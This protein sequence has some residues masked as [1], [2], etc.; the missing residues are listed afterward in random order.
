MPTDIPDPQQLFDERHF[1]E[2]TGLLFEVFGGSRM[3]GRLWGLLVIA[4]EP[5]LSAAE[6]GDRL[7]ASA[8]SVSTATRVLTS[9]GLIERVRLPGDRRGYFRVREGGID[10]LMIQRQMVISQGR[11]LAERGLDEF[12]H[13]RLARDRLEEWR[14]VYAF[15]ERELPTLMEQ[16]QRERK[17]R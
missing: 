3:A 1:A 6:L 9:L 10:N 11:R 14:Q 5:H 4:D 17:T 13:R 15:Y 12:G 16:Y 8:G 2:D 7:G